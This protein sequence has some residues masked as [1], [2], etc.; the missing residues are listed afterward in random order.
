MQL[1]REIRRGSRNYERRGSYDLGFEKSDVEYVHVRY[2]Y[3][4]AAENADY[5]TEIWP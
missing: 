4:S 1:C 5:K 3:R 2:R